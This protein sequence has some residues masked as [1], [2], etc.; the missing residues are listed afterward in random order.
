M[1]AAETTGE[2]THIKVRNIGGIG[3]T[4]VSLEPGLNILTGRNATNRTSFLR[5]IMGALGSDDLSLKADADEGE[6]SLS[7]DGETQTRTLTRQ[8]GTVVTAGDP[9]LDDPELAD[10]FAFLLE[11][12][13]ARQAILR[14]EDLRNIIMRPVDTEAIRAEITDLQQQKQEVKDRLDELDALRR[15]LPDIEAERQDIEARIEAKREELDKREAEIDATNT[16]LEESKAQQQAFHER[17][18]DLKEARSELERVRFRISSQEESLEALRNELDEIE[19][20][21]LSATD[22]DDR[23]AELDAE[24][25]Q[26]RRRQQSLEP[27]LSDLQSIV[28]FNEEMLDEETDPLSTYLENSGTD[29]DAVTDQLIEPDQVVCWTCGTEV[30]RSSIESTVDRLSSVRR[31]LLEERQAVTEQLE[32]LQ[33]ERDRLEEQRKQRQELERRHDQLTSEIDDREEQLATLRDRQAE[34]SETVET[35][36][37]ELEKSPELSQSE[38]IDLHKEANELEFDLQQ[39]EDEREDVEA[40]IETIEAE[41]AEQ[42]EVETRKEEISE[43]LETLRT[44]VDRIEQDAVDQFNDHM[45]AV[46]SLLEYENLERIW[47]ERR[48]TEVKEGRRNAIKRV[49]DLHVVRQSESGTSYE[50]TI[51]HLSESEREVTGLVF[52][53]AGYLVHDVHEV[54]P[55]MLLDSLEAIDAERIERIVNYFK[56]YAPHLIVAL[57][58]EDAEGLPERYERITDI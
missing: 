50:D 2:A 27:T 29:A 54:A 9:Y 32:D 31:D 4:S 8:N 24:I 21:D 36:E 51:D 6:V 41:L 58:P 45:D 42:D 33:V 13:E 11:S 1:P 48:Q 3:E 26:L 46:L 39:L 35:L 19:A 22:D 17:L 49:F 5:A 16:E 47:I 7:V 37:A 43:R 20:T 52:A 14:G 18:D 23:L 25:T 56:E 12:N 30:E 57:L 53:L 34:L 55:F 10:L 40:R 44:K 28:S 15:E 38:I